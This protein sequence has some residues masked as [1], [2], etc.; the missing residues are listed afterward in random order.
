MPLENLPFDVFY[1]IFENLKDFAV[2]YSETLR[3]LRLT[4]KALN[5]MATVALF[6]CVVLFVHF[7]RSWELI[8]HIAHHGK[9]AENV[10][11]LSL[12][13]CP[14]SAK[15]EKG[16]HGGLDL[17]LFPNLSL[18][19]MNRDDLRLQRRRSAKAS[20]KTYRVT[21]GKKPWNT[22]S[23][24]IRLKPEILKK[25]ISELIKVAFQYGFEFDV[26]TQFSEP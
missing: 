13:I 1:I 6:G 9:I 8:Q 26:P 4:S 14:N 25:F 3:T 18:I 21:F 7:P 19:S 5:A 22:T 10:K 2:S 16:F 23:R 24:S 15:T 11:S 17:G 12:D 20:R